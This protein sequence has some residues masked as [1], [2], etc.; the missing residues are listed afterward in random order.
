MDIYPGN[1][2][3]NPTALMTANN[4]LYFVATDPVYGKE[5]Y[6]Y[7]D[8]VVTRLTDVNPG[9]AQGLYTSDQSFPTYYN[10]KIYFCANE[11]NNDMNLGEYD[12][13]NN[14]TNI[15]YCSG[16]GVSG[17]PRY[18]KVWDNK[19]FFSNHSDTTG[20]ELW[21][22]DSNSAPYQVWD[23]NPGLPPGN[24]KFFT[25]FN[26]NLYFNAFNDTS[27][28]EELFRLYKRVDTIVT[29]P[30]AIT[31][32]LMQVELSLS[33]NPVKDMLT[34]TFNNSGDLQYVCS[35]TDL[36]GRKVLETGTRTAEKGGHIEQHIDCS[37]LSAG[38]YILLLKDNNKQVLYS[39][40][41]MKQ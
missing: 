11:P 41:V 25:A 17:I 3:S 34:L 38:T 2:G 16:A 28:A 7:N 9:P 40:K 35:L 5:L 20:I 1:I 22:K 12:I 31:E 13:T 15:I 4:K 36:S 8:T 21:A 32:V 19:L 30:N 24:P 37:Q 33:P 14:T 10:G 6:E 27:T 29:N 23:I 26:G 39:Q 18:F